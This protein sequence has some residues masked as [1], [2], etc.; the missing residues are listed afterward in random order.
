MS[1]INVRDYF[2]RSQAR[3]VFFE[4]RLRGVFAWPHG[5]TA[6][7]LMSPKTLPIIS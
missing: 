3:W 6:E 5:T 1:A 7:T 4:D 2:K